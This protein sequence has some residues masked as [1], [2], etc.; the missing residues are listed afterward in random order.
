MDEM[1]DL[2]TLR[3]LADAL[4]EHDAKVIRFAASEIR[5]LR[6]ALATAERDCLAGLDAVDAAVKSADAAVLAEREACAKMVEN[7]PG[8]AFVLALP[9]EAAHEMVARDVRIAAA[10][11]ARK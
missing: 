6:A 5:E 9:T 10:I 8:G 3:A 7:T 11:R 1:T 2:P 4:D